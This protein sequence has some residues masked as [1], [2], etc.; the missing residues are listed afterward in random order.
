MDRLEVEKTGS[1]GGEMPSTVEELL[2]QLETLSQSQLQHFLNS[3]SSN[4]FRG[5]YLPLWDR[6][7][8]QKQAQKQLAIF[9]SEFIKK[10]PELS[11]S[12]KNH[13]DALFQFVQNWFLEEI[14]FRD[15]DQLVSTWRRFY[16]SDPSSDWPTAYLAALEKLVHLE[17]QRPGIACFLYVYFDVAQFGELG[18]PESCIS[19][20]DQFQTRWVLSLEDMDHNLM[21]RMGW[22]RHHRRIMTQ[23]EIPPNMIDD[24]LDRWSNNGPN[25][26]ETVND[27]LRA[28][29]HLEEMYQQDD[30]IDHQTQKSPITELYTLFGIHN[31]DHHDPQLLYQQY[32]ERHDPGPY[33]VILSGSRDW[34]G[35]IKNMAPVSSQL[36]RDLRPE[37]LK[38]RVFEARTRRELVKRLLSFRRMYLLP[39]GKPQPIEFLVI[40]CHGDKDTV[41]FGEHPYGSHSHFWLDELETENMKV[42]RLFF[43]QNPSIVF[44]SC[45]AGDDESFA[46]MTADVFQAYTSGSPLADRLVSIDVKRDSHHRLILEGHYAYHGSGRHFDRD[47]Q[48]EFSSS[49]NPAFK[50][51]DLG[52]LNL[53]TYEDWLSDLFA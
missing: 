38:L 44:A 15:P 5:S 45:L 50:S 35:F 11:H 12:F 22:L 52:D 23:L 4:E 48:I 33:G 29:I 13:E 24:L 27:N 30:T 9:F 6:L 49:L 51:G 21:P 53:E 18:D 3:L 28:L 1:L 16:N 7:L 31:F 10:Y 37:G 47:S 46:P 42:I 20:F 26:F 32:K 39:T 36:A 8:T 41:T 43:T 2:T 14:G 34:N 25:T 19:W 40:S 17:I